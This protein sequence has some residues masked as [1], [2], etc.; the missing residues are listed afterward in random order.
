MDPMLVLHRTTGGSYMLVELNGSISKLC[1]TAFHLIPY[2]SHTNLTIPV[3]NFTDYDDKE[4][5][6][7]VTIED[8]E[9]DDEE[10]R[11]SEYFEYI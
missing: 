3:P 5:D 7:V 6:H 4:L 9:L 11:P 10:S 8:E 1:F 2:D